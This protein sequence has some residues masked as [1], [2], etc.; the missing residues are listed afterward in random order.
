MCLRVGFGGG[1]VGG[2]LATSK[3]WTQTLDP[4]PENP[5]PRKTWTQ[6]N[7]DPEKSKKRLVSQS[8]I[9]IGGFPRKYLRVKRH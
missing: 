6:K 4:D 3:I 1:G 7:L 5:G 9:Y 8:N 2:E